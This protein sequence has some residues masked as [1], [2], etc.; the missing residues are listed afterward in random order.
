MSDYLTEF[1]NYLIIERGLSANTISAYENDLKRYVKFLA[2]RHR[3]PVEAKQ[4]DVV[5]L[6]YAL[7]EVGL[8]PTS[9]ARNFSTVRTFYK[10]LRGEGLTKTD[11]TEYL[12]APKLW[13]KLPTV[14]DQHEVERLIEQPDSATDLGLR[15]RAM[16]EL[17]YACGLRISELIALRLPNILLDQHCLRVFGKGGKE[18]VVPVG[19]S[20]IDCLKQY[21]TRVRPKLDKGRGEDFMFLNWRGK[22]L[23]RMGFWKILQKYVKESGI[24]KRVSPH[25]LRHSFA[26]HLLEGGADLR[27]VQEMLGHTDISTTQIYTHID[28][29]YLKEVHRT[30]HPRG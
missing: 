14:L 21:Q 18:R 28:R 19:R 20:A 22:S 10:F 9:I 16:L 27:A 8:A 7:R 1:I 26:T 17:M 11:P 2:D 13:K 23:S 30:F 29:E 15:D 4:E 6:F 24:S 3:N 5:A 25:T 12:D